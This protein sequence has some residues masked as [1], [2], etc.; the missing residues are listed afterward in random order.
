[1]SHRDIGIIGYGQTAY[2][3]ASDKPLLAFLA[4]A[5]RR[6][7]ASAGLEK[8][9]VDGLAVGSFQLPPDNAVTLAEQFGMSIGWA[10]LCTAGSGGPIAAVLNAVR[11]IEAGHA[12][13]VL[14]V[15]GD[16]YDVQGLFDMMDQLNSALRDYATPYGFGGPNGLFALVTQKHM[17][18]FGTTREQFGR[19]CV[20]QRANAGLNENA[21]LRKPMTM[22]DYLNARPIADP[23]RL[24]DCVMA[25]AGAEAVVIGALDRVPKGKGVRILSG[26][27]RYNHP[28]GAVTPVEGGW[29][30]FCDRLW[31]DAGC[32]PEEMHFVQ[33]YDDYPVMVAIQLEDL[34]FCAKGGVGQFIDANSMTHDGSLPLNTGGGQL[35]CGQSG[36]GGGLMLL[37]ES[38]C[39]LRG[40]AGARQVAGAV[41]GLASGYGM[42]GYGHGL[43]ATAAVLEVAT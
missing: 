39:Q 38:V 42:V 20:D 13:V 4:D 32:G 6:A 29:T 35:S 41:R 26:Y 19:I 36:M 1:M 43:A 23:L 28:P 40:E 10:Y 8:S 3:K 2:E 31:D 21:L 33:A 22:D 25:C 15:V 9:D 16:A 12:D 11:A 30:Q 27:E 14:C 5:S 37:T 18:E 7:L 24:F 17:N 34:G